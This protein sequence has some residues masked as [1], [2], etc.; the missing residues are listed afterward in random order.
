MPP[1]QCQKYQE[2][3]TKRKAVEFGATWN[4]GDA[5]LITSFFAENDVYHASVGPDALGNSYVGK[6]NIRRGVQDVVAG[7]IGTFEWDFAA[8]IHPILGDELR[9]SDGF[10]LLE[11]LLQRFSVA[12]LHQTTGKLIT[13]ALVVVG[14]QP[15]H[16]PIVAYC[17][18]NL[19]ECVEGRG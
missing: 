7:D 18:V 15:Q 2:S 11:E 1:G 17:S 10:I 14:I 6:D 9:A 5:D 8:T 12:A 4:S 19:T 16:I 3:A 13:D